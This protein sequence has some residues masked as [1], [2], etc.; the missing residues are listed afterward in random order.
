MC[1]AHLLVLG[2]DSHLQRRDPDTRTLEV[3]G[4]LLQ[5]LLQI[6]SRFLVLLCLQAL[7]RAVSHQILHGLRDVHTS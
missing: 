7:P 6:R 2:R 5:L 3:V 1:C 4:E